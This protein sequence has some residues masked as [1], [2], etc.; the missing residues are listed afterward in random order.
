MRKFLSALAVLFVVQ[1]AALAEIKPYVGGG[2]SVEEVPYNQTEIS[3][4]IVGGIDFNKNLGIEGEL[5]IGGETNYGASVFASGKFPVF[6]SLKLH[7]RLGAFV[8]N[9]EAVNFCGSNRCSSYGSGTANYLGVA[10]GVG[11]EYQILEGPLSAKF[12][13]TFYT[14]LETSGDGYRR[15]DKDTWDMVSGSIIYRF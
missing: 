5:L 14:P 15:N 9:R 12:D 4:M 1:P 3:G 2:V 11:A 6:K 13:V 8:H 10:Y 7:G